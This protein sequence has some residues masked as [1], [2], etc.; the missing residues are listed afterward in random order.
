MIVHVLCELLVLAGDG[1]RGLFL[2]VMRKGQKRAKARNQSGLVWALS[3]PGQAVTHNDKYNNS[4]HCNYWQAILALFLHRSDMFQLRGEEKS[5][6][7]PDCDWPILVNC[8]SRSES[9]SCRT[10]DS[11]A[12]Q[13]GWHAAE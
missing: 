4:N 12:A 3:R 8:L 13:G 7:F 1:S 5:C 9:I 11:T 2:L 6:T 10:L